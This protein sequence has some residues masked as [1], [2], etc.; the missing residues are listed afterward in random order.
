MCACGQASRARAARCTHVEV[1]V[2]VC[3]C[4]QVPY[5]ATHNSLTPSC[6]ELIHF[7]DRF[8][9]PSER[10][11]DLA[12]FYPPKKL[13]QDIDALQPAPSAL[14]RSQSELPAHII[15][16][17]SGFQVSEPDKQ[18]SNVTNVF[19]AWSAAWHNSSRQ[20][21]AQGQTHTL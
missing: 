15:I 9:Q 10:V 21:D 17:A 3:V 7:L 1:C 2:C 5:S 4:V 20:S 6:I 13:L 8:V 14:G 12:R 11:A 16:A 18:T 19:Y